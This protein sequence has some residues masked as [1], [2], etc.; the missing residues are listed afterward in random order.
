MHCII[1][2]TANF[3]Y[4]FMKLTNTVTAKNIFEA[5]YILLKHQ[6][7]HIF[8]SERFTLKWYQVKLFLIVLSG[9]FIH[10]LFSNK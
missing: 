10:I 1:L 2:F 7:H 5:S 3:H 8:K 6:E 4:F 9:G